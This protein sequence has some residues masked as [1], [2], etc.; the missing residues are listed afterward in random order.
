MAYIHKSL[1][2]RRKAKRN[3][4]RYLKKLEEN[5][6]DIDRLELTP[7]SGPAHTMSQYFSLDYVVGVHVYCED[8]NRWYSDIEFKVPDGMPKLI[9]VPVKMPCATQEDAEKFAL[10]ILAQLKAKPAKPSLHADYRCFVLDE[11]EF[12]IP[13]E[14]FN[15]MQAQQKAFYGDD[16]RGEYAYVSRRLDEVRASFGGRVT[17]EALEGISEAR[18]LELAAVC[19]MALTAGLNRWPPNKFDETTDTIRGPFAPTQHVEA[20][21]VTTM[22]VNPRKPKGPLH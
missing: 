14:I 10:L 18:T 3:L 4:E 20:G 13:A 9:G 16:E 21:T 11:F 17:K 19:S 2:N 7:N 12:E 8:G 22:R 15:E 6:V 1:D 5:P